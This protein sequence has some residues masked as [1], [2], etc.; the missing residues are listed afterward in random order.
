MIIGAHPNV[1]VPLSTTGLWY[2]FARNLADYDGLTTQEGLERAVDALLASERIRLWDVEIARNDVLEDLPLGDY[3][4]VVDRFLAV[5]ASNKG[6]S[7]WGSIDISTLDN[8]D[9]AFRWFPNSRFI[10]IVRDARDVALSNQSYRYS[11]GNILECAQKWDYRVHANLKMGQILGP[12]RYMVIRY[13]DLVTEPQDVLPGICAFVGVEYSDEMLN[14][15]DMVDGKIPKNRRF[16]WPALDQSLQKTRVNRWKTELSLD[17][18]LIVEDAAGKTMTEL[19]YELTSSRP[20]R[21]SAD[22]LALWY[23]LDRGGRCKRLLARLGLKR[24]MRAER[25]WARQSRRVA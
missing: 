6:K 4:A 14:Y 12:K 25:L 16:L 1:A 8:M 22:F 9:L 23:F 15:P 24:T 10:H 20:K 3:A 7:V 11:T 13:E 5:Y 19:G 18:R 2:D 17:K 21:L